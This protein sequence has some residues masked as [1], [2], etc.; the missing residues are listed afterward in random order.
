MWHTYCTD[1]QAAGVPNGASTAKIYTHMRDDI[2]DEAASKIA[3]FG[4]TQIQC[5]AVKTNATDTR[6]ATTVFLRII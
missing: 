5:K 3:A 1:L 4:A 2:M 6:K